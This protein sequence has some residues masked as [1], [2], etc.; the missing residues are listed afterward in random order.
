MKRNTKRLAGHTHVDVLLLSSL[1]RE[2]DEQ[3]HI[4]K[5]LLVLLVILRRIRIK[6]MEKWRE[7]RSVSCL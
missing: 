7:C 3:R 6:V 1:G 2:R 4:N 5:A